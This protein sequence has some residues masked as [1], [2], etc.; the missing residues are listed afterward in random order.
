MV[1]NLLV[2]LNKIW[3]D[4]QASA[5]LEVVGYTSCSELHIFA[6]YLGRHTLESFLSGLF[7]VNSDDFSR[8]IMYFRNNYLNFN[9]AE[10][11]AM[12]LQT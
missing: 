1:P 12:Q 10:V 8:R 5:C 4:W 3:R 6:L 2:E 11:L 7:I 9:V